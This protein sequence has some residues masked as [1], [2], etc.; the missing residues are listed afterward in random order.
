MLGTTSCSDICI[1]LHLFSN[2]FKSVCNVRIAK[3]IFI[4]EG[5]LEISIETEWASYVRSIGALVFL[6]CGRINLEFLRLFRMTGRV[7]LLYGGI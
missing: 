4:A 5:F 3:L 7:T 6:I 2:A 1:E